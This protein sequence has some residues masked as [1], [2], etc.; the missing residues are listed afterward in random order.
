MGGATRI[1]GCMTAYGDDV[2]LLTRSLSSLAEFADRVVVG[3]GRYRGHESVPEEA[4]V[5]TIVN[6]RKFDADVIVE[7]VWDEREARTRVAAEASPGDWCLWA[8][9][10]EVWTGDPARL[11]ALL[12]EFDP[13]VFVRSKRP[14]RPDL[15]PLW[16]PKMYRYEVGHRFVHDYLVVNAHGQ[17]VTYVHGSPPKNRPHGDGCE[18]DPA[19]GQIEHYREERDQV[20]TSMTGRY[21]VKRLDDGYPA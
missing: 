13:C 19:V 7:D 17:A 14:L 2:S 18:L 6:A 21:Q 4:V 3:V 15:F 1:V 9:A 11:R 8:D 16:V 20:R 5:Q 10:D 12:P